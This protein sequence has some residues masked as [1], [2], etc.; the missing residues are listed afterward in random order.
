MSLDGAQR[1]WVAIRCR[2]LQFSSTPSR[3]TN[4]QWGHPHV[5]NVA[6]V[7]LASLFDR[8]YTRSCRATRVVPASHEDVVT[9]ESQTVIMVKLSLFVPPTITPTKEWHARGIRSRCQGS[10]GSGARG[11]L[12]PGH[13]MPNIEGELILHSMAREPV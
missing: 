12:S 1:S 8:S 4:W 13:S 7:H 6:L 3:L 9:R 11:P 5:G 10:C 2:A